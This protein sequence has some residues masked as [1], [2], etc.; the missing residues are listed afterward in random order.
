MEV[1]TKVD[2]GTTTKIK[3]KTK[4]KSRTPKNS[5][6]EI[7]VA[8]LIES[9]IQFARNLAE[10]FYFNAYK[11]GLK[12]EDMLSAAMWGLCNAARKYNFDLSN[13]EFFRSYAKTRIIGAMLDTLRNDANISNKYYSAL[14]TKRDVAGN[15]IDKKPLL[16]TYLR[17]SKDL[18]RMNSLLE[19]MNLSVNV[20]RS[21]KDVEL[22]YYDQHA[23]EESTLAEE[24]GKAWE[25]VLDNLS[26]KEREV[27]EMY[28]FDGYYLEEIRHNFG[29]SKTTISRWHSEALDRLK[30]VLNDNLELLALIS[31]GGVA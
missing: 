25:N 16:H 17:N 12:K 23:P 28:Y 15:V 24:Q 18:T 1:Q 11:S 7:R 10:K 26:E 20:D 8:K 4:I 2:D 3:A 9:N 27:V 13:N 5:A 29:V 22:T 6:F 21:Y 31:E 14:N 19:L 30:D